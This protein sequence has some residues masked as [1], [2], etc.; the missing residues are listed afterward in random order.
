MDTQVTNLNGIAA[1]RILSPEGI[2]RAQ[3]YLQQQRDRYRSIQP[4]VF[5]SGL[6][7][8][9][10]NE[11]RYVDL[12]RVRKWKRNTDFYIGNQV[13]HDDERTGYWIPDEIDPD[14]PVYVNNQ[15]GYFVRSVAS[16]WT[17]ANTTFNIKARH[18]DD[19]QAKGAARVGGVVIDDWFSR[20]WGA[21][22]R[23]LE[24]KYAQL[25][26]NYFRGFWWSEKSDC[27]V[28]VPKTESINIA[29]EQEGYLCDECGTGGPLSQEPGV[30]NVSN[31]AFG[32]A[33]P[34][35][36]DD[37][38]C[39]SCGSNNVSS[40]GL[41]G[42]SIEAVTGHQ[43]IDGGDVYAEPIDPMEMKLHLHARK[44]ETSPYGVR[45]RLFL[46]DILQDAYPHVEIGDASNSDLILMY[47]R[48]L[49][50]SNGNNTYSIL[51]DSWVEEMG[52]FEEVWLEPAMYSYYITPETINGEY[53]FAPNTKLVEQYP[54]GCWL[55]FVGEKL[56]DI[57]EESKTD[58]IVHGR[59]D[60]VPNS[61]WGRGQD[62]G[63]TQNEQLN[64]T[65]SLWYEIILNLASK[66]TVYNPYK[67][68]PEEITGNP[69]DL[70]QLQNAI[71]DES[72]GQ[73]IWQ[74]QPGG[75]PPDVPAY[76]ETKKR[77]MQSMFASFAT[78][79]GEGDVDVKTATGMAILRDQAI[80]QF[81]PMLELKAG[82]DV[83][84]AQIVMKFY[85]KH[86]LGTRFYYT[87]GA[88]DDNEGTY[89]EKADI[90]GDFL[91]TAKE[92]SY[93]PRS[94]AERRA[95]AMEAVEKG[96]FALP[97][98]L[99]RF[100]LDEMGISFE[101]DDVAPDYRK[102]KM[103]IKRLEELLPHALQAWA[104]EGQPPMLAPDGQ[105]IM[106][107][108]PNPMIVE[109]LAKQIPVEIAQSRS[110]PGMGISIDKNPVH[111]E[112]VDE[113]L[114]TDAGMKA[115][116][117]IR[118]ALML[119]MQQHIDAEAMTRQFL[120]MQEMKSQAPLM[121]APPTGG[122][123][124]GKSSSVEKKTTAPGQGTQPTGN[125]LERRLPLVGAGHQPAGA[126]PMG[127]D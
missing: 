122:G 93:M 89:F 25:T 81:G 53:N 67:I 29:G 31:A 58:R 68:D 48:A 127:G 11:N 85:Q 39:P 109:Y 40:F 103:E 16:Q 98:K 45:R 97:P 102:Q 65:E 35:L 47:Q 73:Y 21:E 20:R 7:H 125:Q 104:E 78:V 34:P 84:T 41:P 115:H 15:Y 113:Y 100:L 112:C 86:W 95:T 33:M 3:T 94:D 5:L 114:L 111:I 19:Y 70:I 118:A 105:M 101:I 79:S 9:I 57:A 12:Q 62:D 28:W 18:S 51:N 116:P 92:G 72:P 27:A 10:S 61:V 43:Q 1:A 44:Y 117:L 22:E 66:M 96:V 56:V 110:I 54:K 4:D 107:P 91:I 42:M 64:E 46:R 126:S 37:G 76:L 30:M 71:Q 80:Q 50:A 36:A 69:R 63:V 59:F 38:S 55:A 87:K 77:N 119:H 74:S 124:A 108:M 83:K 32:N 13:G 60:I 121:P 23:Q 26:G 75:A 52:M 82:V 88:Y 6:R 123:A 24:G 2:R 49:E 99:R 120:A 90:Q 14:N 8:R 106:E 17:R